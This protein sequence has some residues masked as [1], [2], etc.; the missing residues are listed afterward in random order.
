MGETHW[1]ES[2]NRFRALLIA[3]DESS[4]WKQSNAESNRLMYFLEKVFA[5]MITAEKRAR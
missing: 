1:G 3:L 5:K 4:I 2:E